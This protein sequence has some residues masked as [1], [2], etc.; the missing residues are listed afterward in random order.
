M[1]KPRPSTTARRAADMRGRIAE[2]LVALSYMLRGYRLLA[3]RFRC[4]RGEI[5]LIMQRASLLVFIEVKYRHPATEDPI[6]SA[7]P[8]PASRKRLTAAAEYFLARHPA[9]SS[10]ASTTIITIIIL[11]GWFRW[12]VFTGAF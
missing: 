8:P 6:T 5:D 11:H 1:K 2:Y 7:I 10:A 4:H 3:R 12:R 9:A